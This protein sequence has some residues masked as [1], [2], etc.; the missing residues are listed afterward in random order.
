M[1]KVPQ[2]HADLGGLSPGL[3]ACL[4]DLLYNSA[5]SRIVTI[6]PEMRINAKEIKEQRGL[7]QMVHSYNYP[8]RAWLYFLC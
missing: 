7:E 6:T 2:G 4:A 8:K 1:P 3:E 5:C